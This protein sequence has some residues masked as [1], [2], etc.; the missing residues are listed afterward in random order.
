[1]KKTYARLLLSVLVLAAASCEKT[2][3]EAV[4][5]DPP[6]VTP[7]DPLTPSQPVVDYDKYRL[8]DVAAKAG[9]KLGVSFT[10]GEYQNSAVPS[11]LKRDFAAVTFGNEMKQDA[12][13][14]AHGTDNFSR[15]DQMAGWAKDCGAELFG[16][17]LGWHSQQQRAYLNNVISGA[18][19]NNNASLVQRNWNFETG[20]LDGFVTDGFEVVK[21]L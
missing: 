21:S 8:K 20:T 12:I 16:H 13:L 7:P 18:A 1:M 14:Q 17:T 5:L 3:P 6:V 9:L 2:P 15:A 11:I 19:P 10:Y 4:T